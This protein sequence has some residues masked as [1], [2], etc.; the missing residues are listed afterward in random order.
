MS[1]I[2]MALLVLSI[3]L[4]LFRWMIHRY[5]SVDTEAGFM[6]CMSMISRTTFLCL[7]P[8]LPFLIHPSNDLYT[9]II[10]SPQTSLNSCG[11]STATSASA[12]T[13]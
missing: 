12:G 7:A 8:T 3:S 5:K 9:T 6:T 4:S 1:V 13:V 10:S 11:T 2:H